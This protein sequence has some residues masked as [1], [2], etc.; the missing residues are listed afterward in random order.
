MYLGDYENDYADLNVKFTTRNASGAPTTLAG[1]P[2]VRVYKS[3]GLAETAL[4]ITLTVDFDGRTGL[5]NVKV[6]LSSDA[7]YA[8][9]EDYS[10]VIT[11][12]TVGGNSVVGEVIGNFS[13]D[14]RSTVPIKSQTQLMNFDSNNQLNVNM[15]A[16][17]DEELGETTVGRIANNFG[18][19]YD[20]NDAPTLAMV[21]DVANHN[22]TAANQTLIVQMLMLMCRKD[23]GLKTDIAAAL[24]QINSNE[25]SGAGTFDSVTDSEQA[26]ADAVAGVGGA[27]GP[28]ATPYTD[29]VESPAGTPLAGAA[30]WVTTDAAGLNTIAGTLV[31]DAFGSFLFMLDPGTYYL[32]VQKAGHNFSNP[33]TIVVS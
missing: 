21:D 3:N 33:T 31:T 18:G 16:I 2:A 1:T 14:N 24:A 13:I 9:G 25:G 20:N 5:N 15:V 23:A 27:V 6:D 4:G 12:G 7:F 19:F 8:P 11:A 26:I 30:V 29:T 32:W 10:I 22:A 17:L 28:G